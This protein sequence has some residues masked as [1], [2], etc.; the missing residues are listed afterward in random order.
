MAYSPDPRLVKAIKSR[1]PRHLQPIILATALVESGGNPNTRPGDGGRSWGAYQEYDLGRGAGLTPAQR[2][3]PIAS[4]LRAFREF[5]IFYD[6]GARGA[7]LAFRAQRPRNRADYVSKIN[8]ALPVAQQLLGSGGA[9]PADVGSAPPTGPTSPVPASLPAGQLDAKKILKLLRGQTERSLQ[10]IMPTANYRGE[11]MSLAEESLPRAQTVVAA[12]N[13]GAATAQTGTQVAQAPAVNFRG[14]TMGGGPEAHHS[15]ALGNWQSDD[16]YDLMGRAGDP[17]PAMVSG[18]VTK[19]SGKPG[20]DP[21][22]AG[23]GITVRTPQGDLFF[24]H[25][26]SANVKVGQRITPQTILGTLDATTAGGPHLHLGGASRSL[27]D[28][29]AKIY[30]RR[31]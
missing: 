15:R 22:F 10:G 18:T 5:K 17:V 14:F 20:G 30:T 29:L 23:Y 3:D 4:T 24:K 19:I 9:A 16:A 2:Q 11:L 1:V 7:D 21:G 12:R 28:Q 27:I 25:L 6:R 8:A 31:R 26:G 13:V